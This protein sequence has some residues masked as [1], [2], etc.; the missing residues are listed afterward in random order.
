MTNLLSDYLPEA[1]FAA[2]LGKSLPTVKR[3]RRLGIGPDPTFVGRS[4]FYS[5][6]AAEAWLAQQE[7]KRQRQK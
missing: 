1:D 3:W 2:E 7:R 4:V 6:R 5:R